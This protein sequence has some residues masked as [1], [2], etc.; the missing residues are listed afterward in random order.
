MNI[1][2]L[3]LKKVVAIGSIG[4]LIHRAQLMAFCAGQDAHSWEL[5][6]AGTDGAQAVLKEFFSHKNLWHVKLM[7]SVAMSVAM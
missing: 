7:L 3:V 6:P 5:R 4:R 2:E 1:D